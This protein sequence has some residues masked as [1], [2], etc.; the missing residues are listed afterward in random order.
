MNAR[1][2]CAG[3]LI[4]GHCGCSTR[5]TSAGSRRDPVHTPCTAA[6]DSDSS[7]RPES[8]AQCGLQRNAPRMTN[9][10]S[11]THKSLNCGVV[12]AIHKSKL[13]GELKWQ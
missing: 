11:P 7:Q 1:A 2:R 6:R 5:V 9:D 3:A 13:Q 10:P 8:K 12:R 4:A